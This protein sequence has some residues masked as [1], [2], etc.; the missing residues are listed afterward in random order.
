[1][2]PVPGVYRASYQGCGG[3]TV[4]PVTSLFSQYRLLVMQ[5]AFFSSLFVC[6]TQPLPNQTLVITIFARIEV[7]KV[8]CINSGISRK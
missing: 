5:V 4:V 2:Q 1:M 3:G 8:Q 7:M 6:L